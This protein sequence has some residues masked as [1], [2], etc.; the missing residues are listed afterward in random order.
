MLNKVKFT[1][2]ACQL[3]QFYNMN[4]N[5]HMAYLIL[6]YRL[7]YCTQDPVLKEKYQKECAV[8]DSECCKDKLKRKSITIKKKDAE[9]NTNIKKK[10]SIDTTKKNAD[11]ISK[12]P[13]TIQ[14]PKQIMFN[15]TTFFH[16]IL[17]IDFITSQLMSQSNNKKSKQLTGQKVCFNQCRR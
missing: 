8:D 4:N 15:F 17:K 12:I 10:E 2:L 1:S 14:V 3:C 5:N 9:E 13:P 6:F 7:A 16:H 11:I